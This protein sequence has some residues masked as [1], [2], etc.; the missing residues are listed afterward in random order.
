MN[1]TVDH[2]IKTGYSHCTCE[3]YIISGYTPVPHVILADGCSAS[4]Q[5]E[6]GA[7]ILVYLSRQFL[8]YRKEF[9][10]KIDYFDMGKWIIHNAENVARW[11]G[12][13]NTCLDATLIVA[14]LRG[15]RIFV[16][17]YGDGF[18]IYRHPG[19]DIRIVTVSFSDNA[20]GNFI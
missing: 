16:H 1:I 8:K 18:I 15:K 7:R 2:F 9:L 6:M 20:K 10:D 13:V 14:Y 5:T 17:M 19:E 3:D 11:L 12:L 4:A